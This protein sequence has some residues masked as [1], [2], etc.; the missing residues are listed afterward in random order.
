METPTTLVDIAGR[1]NYAKFLAEKGEYLFHVEGDRVA[2]TS[3]LSIAWPN[4]VLRGELLADRGEIFLK[5]DDFEIGL[6]ANYDAT[7]GDLHLKEGDFV[8]DIGPPN[9][10]QIIF[11]PLRSG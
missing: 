6:G 11:L 10:R 5:K 3:M 1:P 8:F 2:K 4:H 7:A 9:R